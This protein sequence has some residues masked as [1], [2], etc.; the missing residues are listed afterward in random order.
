MQTFSSSSFGALSTFESNHTI[1][2]LFRDAV[3][4]DV[5]V[6]AATVF[7]IERTENKSV[8]V[9]AF[10]VHDLM[11]YFVITSSDWGR[12]RGN[13][14]DNSGPV[15]ATV[16]VDSGWM[17]FEGRRSTFAYI[18]TFSF[19][20]INWALAVGSVYIMVVIFK[21]QEVDTEILLLPVTIVLIIPALRGLYIGSPQLGGYMGEFLALMP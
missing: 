18:V 3:P 1:G 10:A 19:L 13:F 7:V 20:G 14:S 5:I 15:P 4:F 21:G 8:P 9:I 6:F 16:E 17:W 12:L 2:Y 11:D